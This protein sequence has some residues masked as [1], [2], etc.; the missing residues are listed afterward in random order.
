V[1]A[2]K[3][4]LLKYSA[5]GGKRITVMMNMREYYAIARA[6]KLGVP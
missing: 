3:A 6:R 2:Q 5:C 1:H 4:P